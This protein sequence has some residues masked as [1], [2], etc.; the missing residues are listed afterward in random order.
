[1]KN[2]SWSRGNQND[3]QSTG[4][5]HVLPI[6]DLRPHVESKY[7]LCKPIIEENGLLIIHNAFDGRDRVEEYDEKLSV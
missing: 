1:M 2:K 6:N 5:I 3:E 4:I 7:C